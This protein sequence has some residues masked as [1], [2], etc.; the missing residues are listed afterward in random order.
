MY[1]HVFIY[2]SVYH[3]LILNEIIEPD[4]VLEYFI[5]VIY[6]NLE[7]L[8]DFSSMVSSFDQIFFLIIFIEKSI[9][10]R[11]DFAKRKRIY[12]TFL[13]YLEIHYRALAKR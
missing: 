13:Y 10:H 2:S 9:S 7:K 12:V 4:I 5:A 3:T 11:S 6:Y 8:L 1:L